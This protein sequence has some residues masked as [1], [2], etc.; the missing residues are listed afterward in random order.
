MM[1]RAERHRPQR[2]RPNHPFDR[3][4]LRGEALSNDLCAMSLAYASRS[5]EK[6]RAAG[7]HLFEGSAL[8]RTQLIALHAS[9]QYSLLSPVLSSARAPNE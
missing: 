7:R 4:T 1:D 8:V 5:H 3:P 9:R 6:D 2:R